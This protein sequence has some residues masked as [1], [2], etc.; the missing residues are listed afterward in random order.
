M[1]VRTFRLKVF[2][3]LKAPQEKMAQVAV[4]LWLKMRDN[5]FAVMD[6]NQDEHDLGWWG[7][8]NGSDVYVY[9]DT[10]T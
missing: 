4:E 2:K 5:T 9:F 3:C 1:S 10:K 7:L 8:E 6:R